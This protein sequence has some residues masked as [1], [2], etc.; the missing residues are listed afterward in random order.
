MLNLL[1]KCIFRLK[2]K[3]RKTSEEERIPRKIIVI[4][5]LNKRQRLAYY[6]VVKNV[7]DNKQLLMIVTGQAGCGKS[8]LI[9]FLL[10]LLG[11]LCIACSYFATAAFNNKGQTLHSVFKLHIR[12]KR[13]NELWGNSLKQLKFSVENKKYL[14][15]DEFSVIT[16]KM[17][18][19]IDRRYM[20][21]AGLTSFLFGNLSVIFVGDIAQLPHFA[22][23]P[24][25]YPKLVLDVVVQNIY[26][27][28]TFR[29]II[30]LKVNQ[31]TNGDS[32]ENFRMLLINLHTGT[33]SKDYWKLPLSHNVRL[34]LSQE[35]RSF[36]IRLTFEN[37]SV[38][39][40]NCVQRRKLEKH[41]TFKAF[42]INSDGFGGLEHVL[43]LSEEAQVM[44]TRNVWLDKGLSNGSIGI[45]TDI[46][47]KEFQCPP[48]LPLDFS[49]EFTLIL[50]KVN[51]N[52]SFNIPS[53][54]RWPRHGKNR[55]AS[56]FYDD[57]NN[58]NNNNN[59][60]KKV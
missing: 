3:Q 22:D 8:I 41:N 52:C 6:I 14:I 36:Q 34:S 46:I 19:W 10:Q 56:F 2:I 33:C 55:I 39:D 18:G 59:N 48:V 51:S 9:D 44:L 45:V 38:F 7:N 60:N 5:L 4:N 24:L 12:G 1:R 25:Y 43:Y 13:C 26:A 29:T 53:L 11:E 35:L 16:Q 31:R 47:S 17:F 42:K 50:E 57:N 37:K 23:K 40:Y 49:I 32:E 28:L 27:Y 21:A 58:N 30:T 54:C 20:Q 15:I